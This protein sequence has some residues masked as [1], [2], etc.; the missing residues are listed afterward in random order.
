[1]ES[2]KVWAVGLAAVTFDGRVLDI[3]YPKGQYGEVDQAV[4]AEQTEKLRILEGRDEAR[5]V[6]N[7]VMTVAVDADSAPASVEDIFLRLHALSW[8]MFK[9][10]K[11][12][13]EGMFEKMRM[14]AWTN[15]GSCDYEGFEDTRLRLM[16]KYGKGVNVRSVDR[17]P[18]MLGFVAPSD[19]RI[20]NSE[21]VRLGAYLA[22]GTQIGYT[23][24]VNYN[25]G[26]LGSA[27][28]EGRLSTGVTVDDG[29][30][31]A[32]GASTAGSLALGHHRRV[33]LGRNCQMG[34]NSGLAIPLGDNC[35]VEA[36]LYLNSDTRV[37]VMPTGGVI[38]GEYG[39]IAD[40]RAV[41]AD[42]LA[43]ISNAM[44]RRNSQSGRVEVVPIPGTSLEYAS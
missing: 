23:G 30:T 29:C 20:A 6:T 44:F 35:K 26:T 25:A 8:R 14:I 5:G 13:L 43:G 33:S 31:V 41:L 40:P 15:H 39:F 28:V 38:P 1:M 16:A 9:P 21:T 24:F 11:V 22:P 34:A 10:N 4:A 37:Y 18:R 12:N 27:R 2:T 7:Q 17:V 32:G 42:E 19:V 3:W 36:G